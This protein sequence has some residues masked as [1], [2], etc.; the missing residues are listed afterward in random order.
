MPAVLKLGWLQHIGEFRRV[1]PFG[2]Y[3]VVPLLIAISE[4]SG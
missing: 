2:E 3:A 1:T 4:G